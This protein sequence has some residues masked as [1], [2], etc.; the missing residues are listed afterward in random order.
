VNVK[1]ASSL[2]LGP[3]GACCLDD[4]ADLAPGAALSIHNR[5]THRQAYPSNSGDASAGQVRGLRHRVP[6]RLCQTRNSRPD[7]RTSNRRDSITIGLLETAELPHSNLRPLP[8][9]QESC[10]EL[11]S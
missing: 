8:E 7:S 3:A 5:R 2:L 9:F 4:L 1:Y 10:L 6:R 11:Y